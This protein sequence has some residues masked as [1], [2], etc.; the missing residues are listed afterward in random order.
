M[1]LKSIGFCLL[2]LLTVV[3]FCTC[4]TDTV[5]SHKGSSAA[6]LYEIFLP[7]YRAGSWAEALPRIE[8]AHEIE[9]ENHLYRYYY[10]VS[11]YRNTRYAEAAEVLAKLPPGYTANSLWFLGES[12]FHAGDIPA[13]LDA[14]AAGLREPDTDGFIHGDYYRLL[15]K[16]YAARGDAASIFALQNKILEYFRR[17]G[18]SD[19]LVRFD[20][21][22]AFLEEG[23]RGLRDIRPLKTVT[24]ID[25]VDAVLDGFSGTSPQWGELAAF[26]RS[27]CPGFYRDT[28]L[29]WMEN[30]GAVKDRAYEHRFMMLIFQRLFARWTDTDG[31]IRQNDNVFDSG[32]IEEIQKQF[33][34][35]SKMI[36]YLSR[37]E[38]LPVLDIE[39]VDGTVVDFGP[40][41]WSGAGVEEKLFYTFDIETA[42]PHPGQIINEKRNS[43]DTF[44]YV[45][46]N[47]E[48]PYVS[49]ACKESGGDSRGGLYLGTTAAARH[50]SY[51]HEF[52]HNIEAAYD[53]VYHFVRHVYLDAYNNFWPPWYKGEGEL[54]YYKLAFDNVIF[55]AG[56]EKLRFR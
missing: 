30:S 46:P 49:Y 36:F 32:L 47:E 35:F 8:R 13:A 55:P 29:Y 3:V 33:D 21:A 17:T 51:V 28:A 11:L 42:V 5:P 10:G 50:I 26:I 34:I 2:S 41:H 6:E 23:I 38:V 15:V 24:Y 52:F 40:R 1:K 20:M 7:F 14:A 12:W 39:M 48:M 45:V 19:H 27:Q 31:S 22:K 4:V 44:I 54:F 9:P 25:A 16:Y 53:G 43:V 37:G 18:S 56:I